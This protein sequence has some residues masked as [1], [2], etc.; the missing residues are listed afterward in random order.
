MCDR[1]GILRS[2]QIIACDKPDVIRNMIK[3]GEVIHLTLE[4]ISQSQ[5]ERMH[6]VSGVTNVKKNSFEAQ[7]NPTQLCVELKAVN[8]LPVL[9]DYLLKEK[10]KLLN[11]KRDEPTLEDAFIQLTQRSG[12][13]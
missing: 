11:Y 3:K 4:N 7:P 10:I 2:G 6:D 13:L 9:F 12:G 1:I 5:I 8:D